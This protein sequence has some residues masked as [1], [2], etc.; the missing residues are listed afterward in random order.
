MVC[1][2]AVRATTEDAEEPL[3]TG[4]T[5]HR[6]I[7]FLRRHEPDRDWWRRSAARPPGS[8]SFLPGARTPDPAERA[9]IWAAAPKECL[10]SRRATK[11]PYP[12]ITDGRASVLPLQ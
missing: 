1:P 10:Q 6:G 2:R 4:R 5:N 9:A 3:A 11:C 8:S 7:L 12:P